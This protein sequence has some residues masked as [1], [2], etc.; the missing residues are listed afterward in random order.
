MLNIAYGF[1]AHRQDLGT[2]DKFKAYELDLGH[3]LRVDQ[4]SDHEGIYDLA[5][6]D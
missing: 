3:K 2:K 6:N 4:Q 1:S 5:Q